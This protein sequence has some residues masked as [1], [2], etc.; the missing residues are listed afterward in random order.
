MADEWFKWERE[1]TI[2]PLFIPLEAAMKP[3]RDYFGT[4]WPDS[5]L[6]Y[7]GNIVLWCGKMDSLVQLGQKMLDFYVVEENKKRLLKDLEKETQNLK[8]SFKEIE[9]TNLAG[10]DNGCLLLLYGKFRQAY[11]DW[12][13][14]GWTAE[15]VAL[16]GERLIKKIVEGQK[17]KIFSILTSTTRKSFSRRAEEDLLRV[18][19]KKKKGQ[20][21]DN[22][23]AVHA[24][25]YFWLH[26]S[27]FKTEVLGKD[28]FSREIKLL[29]KE[30]PEPKQYIEELETLSRDIAE[31]KEKTIKQLE[32][33]KNKALIELIDL[34]GWLQDYRKEYI[35]QACHYLDLL[36]AEIGK[37]NGISAWD[38]KYTLPEDLPLI[39]NKKFDNSEIA[40]RQKNCIIIW[41]EFRDDYELY[42]GQKAIQRENELFREDEKTK[43]I[44]EIDGM[45]ASQGR[46]RGEAFVS[47]SAAEAKNIKP[48]QIL[49][50]SM[51]SPD[52]IVAI[53]RAAA[54]VTNEGGITSH[55]AIVSREFGVPC[56][57]GTK[58]ATK[59][60]KT[61]DYIEVDGIHGKVR[62][63]V[64]ET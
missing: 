53:K 11:I 20:N 24:K 25:K 38:M 59:V 64:K 62:K 42:T 4:S 7:K 48:G 22:E 26:N 57:V 16:Y 19:E 33:G 36:L 3:L 27:Y 32:L 10:L 47:M 40:A 56:V 28:F 35:M 51:T 21:I 52:F 12:Y 30:H 18:A 15:P 60:I 49:V 29:L 34:F 58:I 54:I 44:L 46:V 31:E 5:I 55:A 6:I 2:H 8:H 13:K 39:P 63:L 50:T 61:G 9:E 23:I 14:L 37:R 17:P 1:S 41:K 45:A 43:E